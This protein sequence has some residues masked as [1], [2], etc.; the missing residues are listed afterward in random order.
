[1]HAN[2]VSVWL[3]LKVNVMPGILALKDTEEEK[4]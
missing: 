1:M 2:T 3:V 4:A